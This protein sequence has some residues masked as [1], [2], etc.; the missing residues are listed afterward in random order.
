MR[1]IVSTAAA[2]ALLLFGGA[3]FGG[4]ALVVWKEG[5]AS[6]QRVR[7]GPEEEVA[8]GTGLREGDR[9][10]PAQ[11][12]KVSIRYPD[13]RIDVVPAGK[14]YVVGRVAPLKMTRGN[15]FTHD[16]KRLRELLFDGVVLRGEE[17]ALSPRRRVLSTRP[18]L[19]WVSPGGKGPFRI[20]LGS[21]E[22]VLWK[23]GTGK[24][25]RTLLT[26]GELRVLSADYPAGA[27][28]LKRGDRYYWK[29]EGGAFSRASFFVLGEGEARRVEG[30]IEDYLSGC[31][32]ETTRLNVRGSVLKEYG[33]FGEAVGEFLLL[34]ARCPKEIYPHRALS[35]LFG[36][37]G[38]RKLARDEAD[39]GGGG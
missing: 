13:G 22:G 34:E 2:L 4:E 20:T 24:G 23:G 3:C 39:R 6:L 27:P 1:R 37:L 31:E 14:E 12:A 35:L 38:F 32:D 9:V 10:L 5:H 15:P 26:D 36:E 11:G 28:D 17:G 18:A 33:L 29:V 30:E 16:A 7:S 21:R 25:P 8:V 19:L